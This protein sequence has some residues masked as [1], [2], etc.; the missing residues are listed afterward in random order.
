MIQALIAEG[1]SDFTILK[2]ILD[3]NDIKTQT[4]GS[5]MEALARLEDDVF[6]LIVCDEKLSDMT[7]IELAKKVI[8]KNPMINIAIVSSLPPGEFH[9]ASEGM[10]IFKQLP[11]SLGRPEAEQLI[12]DLNKILQITR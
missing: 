6:N 8:A 7:G 3:E 5:G 11:P 10:G 12:D 1:K 9:E 4:V 2:N